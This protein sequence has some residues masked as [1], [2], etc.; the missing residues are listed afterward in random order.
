MPVQRCETPP[1][2]AGG[3]LLPLESGTVALISFPYLTHLSLP[4]GGS[5]PLAPLAIFAAGSPT[6]LRSAPSQAVQ[7]QLVSRLRINEKQM[8]DLKAE[9][10][11]QTSELMKL[12]RKVN[13]TESLQDKLNTELVSRLRGFEEHLKGQKT[14]ISACEA[15]LAAVV[16]RLNVTEEQLDELRRQSSDRLTAA[17]RDT[18]DLQVRLR[19][20]QKQLEDLKTENLVKLSWMESRLT[21]GLNNTEELV[22]RLRI[23][24][25]QMED[26]KA[27]DTEQTSE[28]MMLWRKV[29]MTESL[30][31]KLNT[32]L[33]S[34]LRGFE[35]H[36]KGQK[37]KISAHLPFCGGTGRSWMAK[38]EREYVREKLR[39]QVGRAVDGGVR[40][41]RCER[42][43]VAE[44]AAVGGR[45]GFR[46]CEAELA[47]VVVRLNVTEE[48][49]DELRR[50]SSGDF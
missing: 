2:T 20:S 11:E 43:A 25:K 49:L 7:V 32:E 3:V 50:Q 42:I 40:C 6:W 34:R 23:N 14:K 38:D 31:D 37:A 15:E 41:T 48:Q 30:Q 39:D 8:E 45:Q 12:W 35:E 22:S 44:A 4:I 27:E 19:V 5:N 28:L 24:E 9:D 33:V 36:L 16:V 47:A 46:A 1:L 29:N 10:T 18:E 13:M 26:L 17:Q 21:E